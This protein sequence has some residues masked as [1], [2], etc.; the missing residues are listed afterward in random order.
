MNLREKMISLQE[1]VAY[2]DAL[3]YCFENDSEH[4]VA[5]VNDILRAAL[6]TAK[7]KELAWEEIAESVFK[8]LN[9]LHQQ[10]PDAGLFDSESRATIAMFSLSTSALRFTI[11]C[12]TKQ[13][14]ERKMTTMMNNVS[15]TEQTPTERYRQLQ[16]GPLQPLPD[17]RLIDALILSLEFDS[18]G[19]HP[20]G[21]AYCKGRP[22]ERRPINLLE[23]LAFVAGMDYCLPAWFL[24]NRLSDVLRVSPARLLQLIDPAHW[25]RVF[26]EGYSRA[27]QIGNNRA[28]AD[29]AIELIRVW[30]VNRAQ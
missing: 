7:A 18:D 12:D 28:M 1:T 2:P 27:A 11:T 24:I 15:V 14:R 19:F 3:D 25:P 20:R 10:Y 6:E 23:H 17:R 22:A 5:A 4:L 21:M 26:Q 8:P 29:C 13:T 16:S 9:N 30:L